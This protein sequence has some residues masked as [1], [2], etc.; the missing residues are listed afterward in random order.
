[1]ENIVIG[2]SGASGVILGLKT[3]EAC[4]RS[5]L[6]VD[7]VMTDAA[8]RTALE[9][10]S[11]SCD[12]DALVVQGF[13]EDLRLMIRCVAIE[14]IG[15]QIASGTYQSCGM[16]IV[17]CSMATLSA[18]STGLA[19]NLLRRAADVTLK[20]GRRLLIVPRETPFSAIHLEHM[21]KLSRLG[22]VI[23]PP[24]PAWYLQ[25]KTIEDVEGNIV[26][27]ILDRFGLPSTLKR[28]G[29]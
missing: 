18:V 9:E 14:N 15:A 16:I 29:D 25:P 8:R 5:G 11:F 20:E 12:T 1:M 26:A 28:W 13:P 19:D 23:M 6:H 10:L 17:P 27:R 21:L 4:C 24:L 22:V 3:V 2:I 7:L